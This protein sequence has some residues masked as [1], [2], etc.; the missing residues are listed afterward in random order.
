MLL[1]DVAITLCYASLLSEYAACMHHSSFVI[2]Y[3]EKSEENN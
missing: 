3:L 2:A 1:G